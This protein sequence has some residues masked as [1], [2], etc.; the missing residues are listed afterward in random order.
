MATRNAPSPKAEE[1]SDV[2]TAQMITLTPTAKSIMSINDKIKIQLRL[3]FTRMPHP[4][5]C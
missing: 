2:S 5:T 4:T 3:S 1:L